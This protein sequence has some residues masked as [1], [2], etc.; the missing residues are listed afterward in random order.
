VP[1]RVR[2]NGEKR[3]WSWTALAGAAVLLA[4]GVAW[5]APLWTGRLP[6]CV[7]R[8]LSGL[9]CPGCGGTRA[10]LALLAG[11]VPRALQMNPL[12]VVLGAVV[13]VLGL[14]AAWR[15]RRGLEPA[16]PALSWRWG[17]GVGLVV[18]G[19]SILRNL[20]WWPLEWM[21]AG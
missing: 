3:G 8:R 2:E 13:L 20:P 5:S 21:A 14:R 18:L 4:G 11:D 15:E 7:F 19:F 12:L 10:T 1:K 16:F 6:G 9:N 17:M